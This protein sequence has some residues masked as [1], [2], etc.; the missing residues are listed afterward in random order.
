V[1]SGA[2]ASVAGASV[3]GASVS[4]GASVAGASVAGASVS[5]G[6]GAAVVS[7]G[8]SVLLQA[9]ADT[10]IIRQRRIA[11]M[12]FILGFSSILFYDVYIITDNFEFVKSKLYFIQVRR[13]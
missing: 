8:V 13:P 10:A 3:A 1:V 6:A 12:R 2:G 7:A 9:T 5:T 11:I 4:T